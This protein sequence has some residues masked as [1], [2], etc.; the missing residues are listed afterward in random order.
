[1][2]DLPVCPCVCLCSSTAGTAGT[3]IEMEP[4][5]LQLRSDVLVKCYAVSSASSQLSPRSDAKLLF[6][7]QFH[8]SA[9]SSHSLEFSA[10]DLDLESP[11]EGHRSLEG[12]RVEF[13]FSPTA[14]TTR[15]KL[16]SLETHTHIQFLSFLSGVTAC[17]SSL[18]RRTSWDC[19]TMFLRAGALPVAQPTASKQWGSEWY[20]QNK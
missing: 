2:A 10:A 4:G 17:W 6:R 9:L 13:K 1:M 20:R 14:S 19:C 18:Q 15:C 16:L 5:L 8:T 3:C 7:C 11:A 12:L